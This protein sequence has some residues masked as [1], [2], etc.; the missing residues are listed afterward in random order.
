M[1]RYCRGVDRFDRE[2]VRSAYHPDALDDHGDFVGGVEDFID[3]AFDYHTC[4][5]HRTM[6]SITN[7]YCELDG[8]TAHSES[9][10]NFIAVNRAAPHHTFASGRYIDRL[11]KRNGR[12][13]IAA[14]ICVMNGLDG[15]T[16]PLAQLG[17]LNFVPSTRDSTDPSYM[18]PLRID[19]ARLTTKC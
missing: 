13:G 10:W 4:H 12:W 8:D 3:W 15:Q 9:Y 17:D 14:R 18:R 19:P 7:H 11:E 1:V 5:Q 16:D 2:M 6:H